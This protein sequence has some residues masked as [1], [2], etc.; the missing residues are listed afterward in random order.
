MCRGH[1]FVKTLRIIAGAVGLA[2]LGFSV[3]GAAEES[4]F[5]IRVRALDIR[6]ANKS[7]AIPA[8]GVASDKI[9]V[10]S[11]WI[12]DIDLEYYVSPAWSTELVLTVPQKHD[13][14]V[15][16]VGSLGSFKHLPPTLTAK[17]HFNPGGTVS[18]YIGAGINLTLIMDVNLAV[19]GAAPAGQGNSGV[20]RQAVRPVVHAAAGDLPLTLENHSIGAAVQAG[21]DF[22]LADHWYG[23]VD[24]KY[25]Q[26]RSDVML[27]GGTKVSAVQVD[28]LLVGVGVA[29]RF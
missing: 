2:I 4:P 20:V 10:S 12:P 22:R 8:L 9:D 23:N 28:P 13:V 18:P 19:P 14:S 17:Y 25:V 24:L 3:A 11:K 15:E 27:A 26:I 5:L 1:K 16:G 29:Y 21:V 6:P 7:D